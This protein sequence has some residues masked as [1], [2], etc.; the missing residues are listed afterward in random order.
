MTTEGHTTDA[1]AAAAFGSILQW[2]ELTS[3]AARLLA[4]LMSPAGGDC[5]HMADAWT[6]S[7]SDAWQLQT[8]RYLTGPESAIDCEY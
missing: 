1:A 3:C 2:H 6:P 7:H 4:V 5:M 8:S